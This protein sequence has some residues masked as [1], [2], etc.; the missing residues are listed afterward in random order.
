MS[1]DIYIGNAVLEKDEDGN[2][3]EVVERMEHPD[4]PFWESKPDEDNS[5]HKMVFI[6]DL[7]RKTNGRH[8]GYSQMSRFCEDAGLSDLFFGEPHGILSRHPGLVRLSGKHFLELRA[9]KERW[10]ENH[11]DAVPGWNKGEDPILARLIWYEWWICWA[12]E[13]CENPAVENF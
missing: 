3:R 2:I 5:E 1:Y 12:L 6:P 10:L 7:S 9:A 13:H 4:A 11:P 8:P